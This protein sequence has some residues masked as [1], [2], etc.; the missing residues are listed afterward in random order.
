MA[1]GEDP[2][3]GQRQVAVRWAMPPAGEW[4]YC[5][6]CRGELVRSRLD[7]LVH[8]CCP[9]C[10]FV[11]WERPAPA[12]VALVRDGEERLLY[13]RRRYPPEPG[14]WCF[15][16]G[17]VE[18]GESAEDAAVRE[19]WE[20]TGIRI[21]VDRQI[22]VFSPPSRRSLIAFVLAHPVGGRLTPG[23]DALD[24]GWFRPA[25]APPLCFE[26]HAAAFAA[27]VEQERAARQGPGGPT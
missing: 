15:P 11:Y 3:S 7:G 26:T 4:R 22:G 10:G 18:A 24:A 6:L 12:A 20:E 1:D 17:G 21:A 9:R 8:P 27:W 16:G 5:P 25:A 14:G 2:E 23:S 19:V 13:T